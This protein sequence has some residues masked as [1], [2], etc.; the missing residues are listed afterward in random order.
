MT[1]EIRVG[2]VR[3]VL[4]GIPDE[5]IDMVCT[6][7]PYFRLRRYLDDDDPD[8]HLEIGHEDSPSA[9]VAV[10]VDV[11][12]EV[13]RVLKKT[14]VVWLNIGDSYANQGG[15]GQG[16]HGRLAQKRAALLGARKMPMRS[17]AAWGVRRK[18]MLLIP[19]RLM[20]ALQDDGW[21]IRR[22]IVWHKKNPL[23]ESTTDRPTVS[24]E[25]VYMLTRSKKYYWNREAAQVPA[26]EN[27]HPRTSKRRPKVPG[28][29][30]N[31]SVHS[32]TDAQG[33]KRR[34]KPPN[35][36]KA[37]PD[38]EGGVKANEIFLSAVSEK[39]VETRNIRDVWSTSTEPFYGDHF[40][41]FPTEIAR[42]C[43]E[44]TCPPGGKVCDPF[45]GAGTVGLV[46]QR[47]DRDA[48]IIEL[49]KKY[50]QMSR[51]RIADDAPLL[52]EPPIMIYVPEFHP[53]IKAIAAEGELGGDQTVATP[54]LSA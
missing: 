43:I 51:N 35:I 8:R 41:T 54:T 38:R 42:I 4:A 19:E 45:G 46:A 26:S 21:R 14:G 3:R 1:V 40:A 12:R 2:D 9:Y 22:R 49:S 52:C 28:N 10:I 11:M 5:S 39:V 7:P 36:K 25:L 50:A 34:T 30:I 6:S 18:D 32:Y 31:G 17:R 37:M 47:L 24:H 53:G 33:R 20:I 29:W 27:T 13:R 48:I 15:G 16:K 44:L 23:P